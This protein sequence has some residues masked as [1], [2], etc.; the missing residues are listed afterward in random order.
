MAVGTDDVS[1]F[2]ARQFNQGFIEML[3]MREFKSG[4][5]NQPHFIGLPDALFLAAG[6]GSDRELKGGVV[7][8]KVMDIGEL[9]ACMAIFDI[10]MAGDAL[11][12]VVTHQTVS[13][14]VVQVT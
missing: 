13:S 5:F 1:R 12:R 8:A 11:M 9:A 7:D 4:M 14:S 10:A 6:T 3:Q 2:I